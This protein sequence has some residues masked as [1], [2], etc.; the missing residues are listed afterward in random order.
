MEDLDVG[1]DGYSDDHLDALPD[2]AL[3]ELQENAIRSTQQ[4]ITRGQL[5]APGQS[6]R[7]G[8]PDPAGGFG[9]SLVG[10]A[11]TDIPLQRVPLLPS[12]DY[13]DF[14]DEMLDGEIFDAAEEPA[15]AAEYEAANGLRG[16]GE[17][18][19]REEWRQRRYG[20]SPLIVEPLRNQQLER[21]PVVIKP[22]PASSNQMDKRVSAVNGN[23]SVTAGAHNMSMQP[24][25]KGSVDVDAL[26]V[27]VQKLLREREILQQGIQSANDSAFSKAGEIAI[28]RANAT[29]VEKEYEARTKVLQKMHADEAARQKMEVE[30]AR[31]ELQKIATEKDFLENDVA[32]GTKQIRNLQKAIK[33]GDRSIGKENQLATPKKTKSLPLRDGFDDNEVLPMSPSKLALRSKANTP[34]AGTKRKRKA[35]EDSPIKPLELAQPQQSISFEDVNHEQSHA[36]PSAVA[37][38]SRRLDQRFWLTQRLLNHR[39]TSDGPR[40]FERLSTFSFPSQPDKPLSTI[41]L[42]ESSTLTYNP[43]IDNFPSAIGLIIIS[44]WSR[45]MEESFHQPVHMLVELVKFVLELNAIKTAPDLTNELMSLVQ[46]TADVILVPRCQKKPPRKDRAEINSTEC[47]YIMQMMAYDCQGDDEEISR[48]WRTMRFD[49]IMMLLNFINPLHEIHL[50]LSLLRTSILDHSFAMI[51]PPNNGQQDASEAHIIENLSHLLINTPRPPPGEDPP[52]AA[53]ICKLRLKVLSL[54][55]AMCDTA[56]SAESLA[57]HRLVIGCLVRVMNDELDRVYDHQYGHELRIALV[58]ESTRLLYHLT[59]NYPQ[60]I[61]MQA[62]LSVVPG[63]EKKFLIALTRLAFSEGGFYEHDIEDDVVDCAHQ[64]LEAR[65]S[66]E[67]AEGL[68]EAFSTAPVSRK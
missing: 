65:V 42:D 30:K 10:E 68:V 67:E 21:T 25:Q 38:V 27:Q 20:P 29:K 35:P 62:K 13:G 24:A 39:S 54:I 34:K 41:F 32:E 22:P 8:D 7:A 48:F 12:S 40:I 50:M 33:K 1:D 46:S 23:L 66:P 57:K 17:T 37:Q 56:H 64:M 11:V 59:T 14:D 28:V 61:D 6:S 4:T 52:D 3:E 45:C 53:A 43:D 31:A 51:V 44:I 63:G 49:F 19:Q 60:F 18:T 26:Q 55:E 5:P 36:V 47:L 9:R 15:L 2:H 58:N 16:I